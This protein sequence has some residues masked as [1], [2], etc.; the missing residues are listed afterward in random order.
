MRRRIVTRALVALA[1]AVCMGAVTPTPAGAVTATSHKDPRMVDIDTPVYVGYNSTLKAYH[2]YVTG[3]WNPVCSGS[4]YCWPKVSA[5]WDGQI[6]S[7]DAIRMRF[8]DSVAFNQFKVTAYDVCG[9]VQ[10]TKTRKTG[11]TGSFDNAFAGVNDQV[12]AGWTKTTWTSPTGSG[13]TSDGTCKRD[14]EPVSGMAAG[15]GGGSGTVTW[16][17]DSHGRAFRYDVWV[18]PLPSQG[19]CYDRLYVKGGYTHTWSDSGLAWSV[20]LGYPWGV[21]VGVGPVSG[22]SDFTVWQGG[23]GYSDPDLKTPRMCHHAG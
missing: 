21:S 13:S 10:Y 16:W 20:G 2:L 17:A 6:G 5:N 12:F 8:S 7:N 23:D 15:G 14:S 18:N 1:F 11:S 9:N 4:K 22:S 19:R 3:R